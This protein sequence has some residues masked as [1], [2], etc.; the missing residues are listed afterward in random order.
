MTDN[1]RELVLSLFD[2]F[3]IDYPSSMCFVKMGALA[4]LRHVSSLTWNTW[5]F[6]L[7]NV[8]VWSSCFSYAASLMRVLMSKIF[9]FYSN[10]KTNTK[11]IKISRCI[12]CSV[13]GFWIV[14]KFVYG[15]S[16]HQ[17]GNCRDSENNSEWTSVDV[18]SLPARLHECGVLFRLICVTH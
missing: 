9:L 2:R 16:V 3:S 12:L 4:W 11:P 1:S 7:S 6:I 15:M 10:R 18:E 14:P 17:H 5:P 13:S 8:K